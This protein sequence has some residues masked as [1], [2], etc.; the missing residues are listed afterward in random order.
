MCLRT[1]TDGILNAYV[2]LYQLLDLT[3]LLRFLDLI[4][5]IQIFISSLA[6]Y[7]AHNVLSL[8]DKNLDHNSWN[9][10]VLYMG[11]ILAGLHWFLKNSFDQTLNT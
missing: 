7:H 8:F 9:S 2:H 3:L 4:L 5:I 11:D 10:A 1:C 6:S